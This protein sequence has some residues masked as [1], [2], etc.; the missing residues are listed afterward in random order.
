[1]KKQITVNIPDGDYCE[2][3]D[4]HHCQFMALK[5]CEDPILPA[6]MLNACHAESSVNITDF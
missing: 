4:G 3:S 2:S 1:M 5:G 6:L